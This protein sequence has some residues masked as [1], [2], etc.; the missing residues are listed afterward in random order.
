MHN[1]KYISCL[2]SGIING[3]VTVTRSN[4]NSTP[5]LLQYEVAV[6]IQRDV[7]SGLLQKNEA[8]SID[9]DALPLIHKDFF[10]NIYWLQYCPCET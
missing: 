6:V 2:R 4:F 8:R 5:T 9:G 1:N 7:E 10:S 3:T